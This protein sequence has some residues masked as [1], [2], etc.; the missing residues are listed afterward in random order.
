[1]PFPRRETV[2]SIA[3]GFEG[4]GHRF[5]VELEGEHGVRDALCFGKWSTM[6]QTSLMAFKSKVTSSAHASSR[7][8]VPR[9]VKSRT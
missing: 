1:M 5:P 9:Q 4:E 6:Y 2:R 7:S 8:L 3:P